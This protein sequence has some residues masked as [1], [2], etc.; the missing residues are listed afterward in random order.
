MGRQ[1]TMARV[2]FITKG[3]ELPD[4]ARPVAQRLKQFGFTWR[5]SEEYP[6]GDK[7]KRVQVRNESTL[8]PLREVSKYAQDMKRGDQFPPV[9]VTADGY[10]VDGATRTEATRK[11]GWKTIATFVLDISFGDATPAQQKQLIYMG[12]GANLI[13]GRGMSTANVADIIEIITDDNDTPSDVARKLH[14]SNSTATTLLNASN[15][16]KRAVR[17]GVEVTGVLTNSALKLFG[18]KSQRFTD[19]VFAGFFQLAQDARLSHSA[20]NN[21]SKR[22]EAAGTE[23]ERMTILEEERGLYR[24]IIEGGATSPSPAAKLRQNLGFLLRMNSPEDLI[25]HELG[26]V[27]THRT[28]LAEAAEKLLKVIQEQRQA[29]EAR[30]VRTGR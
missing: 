21:L 16:R 1:G 6:L 4:Y 3:T 11:L 25:E 9:V 20:L 18:G 15:A 30:L 7:S 13:H 12:A 10:L 14:I 23:H 26:A 2:T 28:V 5:F 19:P 29:D 22:L 8:A 24:D 17:L 27:E